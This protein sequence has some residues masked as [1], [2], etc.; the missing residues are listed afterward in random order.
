M[1]LRYLIS[2]LIFF[3]AISAATIQAQTITQ[4]RI[5]FENA[6]HHEAEVEIHYTNLEDKVLEIRMSRTSPGRYAL[7]EFAKNVYSASA[8][9]EH[10]DELN[11]TRPN[12]HQ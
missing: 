5:S 6:V 2:I 11:I 7:H 10:G 4:Y 3:V 8:V 12:P 9:D 1:K